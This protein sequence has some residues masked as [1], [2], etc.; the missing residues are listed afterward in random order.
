MPANLA[1]LP[2]V[3]SGNLRL[4]ELVNM[5]ATQLQMWHAVAFYHFHGTAQCTSR[6][7]CPAVALACQGFYQAASTISLVCQVLA[8]KLEVTAARVLTIID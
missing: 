8:S 3:A 4:S 6:L 7:A 5:A 1:E 2:V